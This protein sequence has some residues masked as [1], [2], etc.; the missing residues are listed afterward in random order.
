MIFLTFFE[1][2]ITA[3]LEQ[4]IKSLFRASRYSQAGPDHPDDSKIAQNTK[5]RKTGNSRRREGSTDSK[6]DVPPSF[7]EYA[8]LTKARKTRSGRENS[9]SKINQNKSKTEYNRGSFKL[10]TSGVSNFRD[11]SASESSSKLQ[12]S[13]ITHKSKNPK[14]RHKKHRSQLAHQ[15]FPL[16]NE[17]LVGGREP[18]SNPHTKLE[19]FS[20]GLAQISHIREPEVSSKLVELQERLERAE[21]WQERETEAKLRLELELKR[22]R[23][24]L[25]ASKKLLMVA[26]QEVHHTHSQNKILL[27]EKER[28]ESKVTALEGASGGRDRGG[29]SGG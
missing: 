18:V 19:R 1:G 13:R 8:R 21:K 24:S 26:K 2:E 11:L 29:E 27:D 10:F 20:E 9:D 3:N 12:N 22:A 6:E 4:K 5:N 16:H 14:N 23:Q 15:H 25:R 28:L 17:Y 7:L